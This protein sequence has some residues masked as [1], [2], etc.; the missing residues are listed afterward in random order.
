MTDAVESLPVQTGGRWPAGKSGNPKGRPKDVRTIQVVKNDLEL[1][2]REKLSVTKVTQVVNRMIELALQGDTKA[3]KLIFD[4][5]LS[6]GALADLQQTKPSIHI[7]IENATL[8]AA[9]AQQEAKPI[10]GS[11]DVVLTQDH[12]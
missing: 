8:N 11:Y 5:A 2:V 12:G 6:K 1:A 3:A 9:K 4:M 10:E 7:V